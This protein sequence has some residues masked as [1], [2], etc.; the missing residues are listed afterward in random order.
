MPKNHF[1]HM[2]NLFLLSLLALAL[3]LAA[4]GTAVPPVS[5]A[6]TG[7]TV[8]PERAPLE[9]ARPVP[10][11]E[12]TPFVPP[13]RENGRGQG[14]NPAPGNDGAPG[15]GRGPG[16]GNPVLPTGEVTAVES[17][18]LQFMREE[19]KM[20]RDVYLAL[21]ALWGVPV[22]DNIAASEQA[23]MAAVG[24]LLD[25]YGLVD[26]AAGQAQGVFSNPDLQALH[27]RLMAQGRGSL[28][29][30]LLA[31][32]AIEEIDILDLQER[33]A[34][35]Q[36]TAVI[37]VFQNLLAGSENHLRA[38]ATNYQRQTGD[39]YAPQ[40]MSQDAYQ[41][42]LNGTSGRGM[43]PGEG[44]GDG[45]GRGSGGQGSPGNGRGGPGNGNKN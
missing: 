24:N 5:A 39:A 12:E 8:A 37:Q 9:P 16:T 34:Q 38:F 31:G 44:N 2:R 6:P 40:V 4:C 1:A 22:F 10:A 25:H 29:G 35:T 42:I 11:I 41:A 43:G 19:E 23:H 45:Q 13:V 7:D 21:Y 15:T 28:A 14:Q 26:P 17:D 30:A 27:D 36:N 32:G 33:L 18:A 3:L 20:A